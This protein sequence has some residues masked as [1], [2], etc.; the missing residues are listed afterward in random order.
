MDH[1][2]L[3]P[4]TNRDGGARAWHHGGSPW[5]RRP[6]PQSVH[7]PHETRVQN[8]I[9]GMAIPKIEFLPRLW[10]CPALVT[11]HTE[12]IAPRRPIARLRPPIHKGKPP[13]KSPT[14]R[15]RYS[16][17]RS[18][19]W[20]RSAAHAVGAPVEVSRAWT[21]RRPID[22]EQRIRVEE[23]VGANPILISRWS[24]RGGW[25]S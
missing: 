25:A 1:A 22:W 19:E 5:L 3:L 24:G 21:G 16:A 8:E 13:I 20:H 9:Q 10:Q 12:G 7:D 23:K 17:G 4:L 14:T 6:M 2:Y 11:A 18:T 15:R